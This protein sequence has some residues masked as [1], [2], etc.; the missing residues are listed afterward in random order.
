MSEE[1]PDTLSPETK[2]YF[3]LVA[4]DPNNWV[5]RKEA[6]LKLYDDGEYVMAADMVWNTSEIPSTD[7]DMAFAVKMLSRAK[8]NRSI[9]L[10]YELLRQ[11]SGKAEQAIAL[12]NVFNLIGY[13]MLASRCYG[14]AISLNPEFFDIGF[15]HDSFWSDDDRAL[16]KALDASSFARHPHFA[17]QGR[18]LQGEAIH[19]SDLTQELDKDSFKAASEAAALGDVTGLVP[20]FEKLQV[21]MQPNAR[22]QERR[23]AV[24]M[25]PQ[26]RTPSGGDHSALYQDRVGVA[27]R[28]VDESQ[29]PPPVLPPVRSSHAEPSSQ[30]VSASP[31]QSNPPAKVPTS[32]LQ[33]PAV[34]KVPTQVSPTLKLNT[35]ASASQKLV[36]PAVTQKLKEAPV[37]VL[38]INKTPPS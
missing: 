12:A 35:G 9:R 15:E 23:E 28:I 26:A 6:A 17:L 19:F 4:G 34:P 38:K 31:G 32:Q 2:I 27:P 18:E 1:L 14:A 37:P 7:M 16:D 22:K 13:P 33:V 3:N 5:L 21:V 20:A 11:N 8:P 25:A 29:L 30:P 36:A 10:V 24:P